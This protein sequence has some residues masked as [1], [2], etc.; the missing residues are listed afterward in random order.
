MFNI[1]YVCVICAQS[2]DRLITFNRHISTCTVPVA[3]EALVDNI[4]CDLCQY[5]FVTRNLYDWHDCFIQ[6]NGKC[7]KCQRVFG[8]K[9]VLFKHI[10]KCEGK[11][12]LRRSQIVVEIPGQGELRLGLSELRRPLTTA[13]KAEPEAILDPGPAIGDFEPDDEYN[14]MG[15]DHFMDSHADD[16]DY[17]SD[18]QG[19]NE[20]PSLPAAAESDPPQST[21]LASKRSALLSECESRVLRV[22]LENIEPTLAAK[23]TPSTSST[24]ESKSCP[25]K[26]KNKKSKNHK[27][28]QRYRED[29]ATNTL[30]SIRVKQEPVDYTDEYPAMDHV[31]DE[32]PLPSH[33]ISQPRISIKKEVLQAEYGDFDS[34][35]ARN[36]KRE[37]GESNS[38]KPPPLRLKIQK[39]HGSLNATILNDVPSPAP[40]AHLIESEVTHPA[41]VINTIEASHKE[42]RSKKLYKKPALLA[43]KIKQER[44]E[45]EELINGVFDNDDAAPDEYI[46]SSDTAYNDV[47][48]QSTLPSLR[49]EIR[50]P[51][52]A[53][54][55]SVAEVGSAQGTAHMLALAFPA[56]ETG[57][58]ADEP[59]STATLSTKNSFTP[60]RIKLEPQ[61]RTFNYMSEV[62]EEE[63]HVTMNITNSFQP[64]GS[65]SSQPPCPSDEILPPDNVSVPDTSLGN[66]TESS[67]IEK[68]YFKKMP[69]ENLAMEIMPTENL[70]AESL[71]VANPSA[72]NLTLNT[73]EIADTMPTSSLSLLETLSPEYSIINRNLTDSNSKGTKVAEGWSNDLPNVEDVEFTMLRESDSSD[74]KNKVTAT[75]CTEF[76]HLD[77]M[78]TS[79]AN[80]KD[81][82]SIEKV[83]IE[84]D[85]P[86]ANLFSEL[87]LLLTDNRD[88]YAATESHSLQ[89]IQDGRTPGI[90]EIEASNGDEENLLSE[91]ETLLTSNKD[92]LNYAEEETELETDLHNIIQEPS[93]P[94]L[95]EIEESID[96]KENHILRDQSVSVAFTKQTP[97]ISMANN[98]QD[99]PIDPTCDSYDVEGSGFVIQSMKNSSSKDDLLQ[100]ENIPTEPAHLVSNEENGG[101][102][103][104]DDQVKPASST[105]VEEIENTPVNDSQNDI[106]S[107]TCEPVSLDNNLDLL[108]KTSECM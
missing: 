41:V 89:G 96:S 93:T 87:D 14:D 73:L 38:F 106:G 99:K 2:F 13:V 49:Q 18:D 105:H 69:V 47:A 91:L 78:E 92:N 10:F 23:A 29:A 11:T 37:R 101:M 1:A 24:S 77:L 98:E 107:T 15:D 65:C 108:E 36:I 70:P 4:T 43:I 86:E 75:E 42:H 32:Q 27:Q 80:V 59:A 39:R 52:I 30:L 16:A 12:V 61:D 9:A 97:V 88:N 76:N 83:T 62:C 50:L 55:S 8:K 7:S 26:K 60:V 22:C 51:V 57:N 81:T 90:P 66:P 33:S 64:S 5:Y 40:S 58:P 25:I 44:V 35:V 95:C 72:D 84:N 48:G 19:T 63:R 21:Y 85:S 17:S 82:T 56:D 54:V 103:E 45:R 104:H 34:E 46:N 74:E 71:T 53:E 102:D 68:I 100:C 6:N 94:K 31:E 67:S 3:A 20:P 28:N 79:I